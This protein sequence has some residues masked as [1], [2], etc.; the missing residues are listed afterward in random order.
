[1]LQTLH[2]ICRDGFLNSINS[3]THT[4]THTHRQT[5]THTRTHTHTHMST[6]R[7]VF[8]RTVA[9]L[10]LNMVYLSFGKPI[11]F[12]SDRLKLRT[13]QLAPGNGLLHAAFTTLSRCRLILELVCLDF[14][15][16][17]HHL[18]MPNLICRFQTK[19]CEATS[20]NL[21]PVKLFAWAWTWMSHGAFGLFVQ[22]C[23]VEKLKHIIS[24]EWT[25]NSPRPS[26]D[27]LN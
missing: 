7:V 21:R 14:R 12:W 5:Q 25:R 20:K 18:G 9:G 2:R 16:P 4:S 11:S 6:T 1:M 24:Q 19:N 10:Y 17:E 15:Q 22:R 3:H 13:T 26:I 23:L 27:L 8:D